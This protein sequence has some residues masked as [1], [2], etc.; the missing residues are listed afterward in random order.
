MTLL[1]LGLKFQNTIFVWADSVLIRCWTKY[2]KYK[3][4]IIDD[5][6]IPADLHA[7]Q[8]FNVDR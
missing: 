4:K 6:V 1:V 3:T 7:N 5:V 2:S 8:S